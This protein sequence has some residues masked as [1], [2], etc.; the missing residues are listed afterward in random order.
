MKPDTMTSR[1]TH[2][3]RSNGYD[4][5]PHG[6]RH[7]YCTLLFAAG[8]NIKTVQYLMG[9]DDAKTTLKVYTH[10]LKSNGVKAATA[11]TKLMDSLSETNIVDLSPTMAEQ[12]AANIPDCQLPIPTNR[13][14]EQ[15]AP[16]PQ[17]PEAPKPEKKA[18]PETPGLA[19][20]KKA[21]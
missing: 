16:T 7:T 11:I 3:C 13:I 8:V 4:V 9:H 17:Q 15:T 19:T 21:V 5:T 14:P 2:Y 20:L 12:A 18:R 10:Y 1:V 6:L